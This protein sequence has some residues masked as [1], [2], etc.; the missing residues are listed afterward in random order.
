MQPWWRLLCSQLP[1]PRTGLFCSQSQTGLIS[2][3]NTS[4]V[5]RSKCIWSEDIPNLA[6]QS[7]ACV[8]SVAKSCLTLATAAHQAPL[9]MGFSRQEHWS[10]LPFPPSGDL[11][12]PGIEH[13][14]PWQVESLPLC[15]PGKPRCSTLLLLLLSRFSRVRLCDPIDGSPPGSPVPGIL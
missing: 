1:P 9:S 12:K 2:Y 4:L 15:P 8:C 10:R 14:L 3:S 13:L 11:P 5:R 7:F 6:A